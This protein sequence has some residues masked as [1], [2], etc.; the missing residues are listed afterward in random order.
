VDLNKI[1]EEEVDKII[2]ITE[3]KTIIKEE[4]WKVTKSKLILILTKIKITWLVTKTETKIKTKLLSK[5]KMQSHRIT[6]Q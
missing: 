4:E 3:G 5:I 2:W 6:K 1:I